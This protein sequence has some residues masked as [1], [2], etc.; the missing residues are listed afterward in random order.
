[1][2]ILLAE[3]AMG[4]GLEGTL[5]LEGKAMVSTLADSFQ[6]MGHEVIYI[7]AGSTIKSGD[8]IPS[9]T[10][11]FSSVL[12]KASQES[13]AG[14]VIGPDVLLEGMTAILEKNTVNLGC[15]ASCVRK[16]ADKLECTEILE[17]ES[18]GVPAIL[19]RNYKGKVVKKPRFG[20]ASEGVRM[21]FAANTGDEE[22]E[23]I[24]TEYIEGEHLSVSVICGQKTVPLSLNRQLIER[25]ENE[26]DIIFE[27]KG[28]QIP[29][30]A[31]YREEVFSTVKKTVEVLGCSGFVGV[32]VIYGDKPYV[33]DVNPRPTTAI[34]GLVKI[35]K[36]EIGELI[37]RNRFGALPDSVNL[38]G[39]CSFTK[40]DIEDII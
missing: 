8:R 40:D 26:E 5:L 21:T 39:E 29:Y 17:R 19:D 31:D 27:Y 36:C 33:I 13:D 23:C 35:L 34:F 18:V 22:E 28:N 1:M 38:E 7:S 25:Q 20:C 16:C 2:K 37:L 24:L 4:I 32:D 30:K 10:D 14:L 12:E 11:S 3:Y 6:N 9:D 15:T